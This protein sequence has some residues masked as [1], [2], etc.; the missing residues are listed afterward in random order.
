M[1]VIDGTHCYCITSQVLSSVYSSHWMSNWAAS[2]NVII[3]WSTREAVRRHK[4]DLG[5]C[6]MMAGSFIIVPWLLWL[7]PG[8]TLITLSMSTTLTST[9]LGH[10]EGEERASL[11]STSSEWSFDRTVTG[12]KTSWKNPNLG[13]VWHLRLVFI[14][15]MFWNTPYYLILSSFNKPHV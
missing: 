13:S 4:C 11:S 7:C 10:H 8:P 12:S 2:L 1:T 9:N 14:Y 6:L 5:Y 3:L 15:F